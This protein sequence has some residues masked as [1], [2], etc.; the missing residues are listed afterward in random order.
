MG[1]V[2]D[3]AL[4]MNASSFASPMIDEPGVEALRDAVHRAEKDAALAEDV[5]LVLAFQ[6]RFEGIR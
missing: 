2:I 4:L 5:G 1:P 3:S 6:R